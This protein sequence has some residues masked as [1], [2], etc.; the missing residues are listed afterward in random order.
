M[1]KEFF[2]NISIY[3]ILPIVGKF[4]NFLLL[5]VYVKIFTPEEYGVVDLFEVLVLFLFVFASLQIPTAFGR[6]FYENN[7]Q[8]YKK[9]IFCTSFVLTIIVSLITIVVAYLLKGPILRL[10]IESDKYG[11]LFDLSMLWLFVLNINTFLS[12][13]PRY[14]NR[15]K[16]YVIVGIISVAIKLLAS[17][18]FV[19]YL[20]IGL[21]GVIYGYICGNTIS[22]LLYAYISRGYFSLNFS[23]AFAKK[24]LKYVLP[25]LLGAVVIELWKP[26]LRVCINTFFSLSVLGLYAFAAR[27]NSITTIVYGALGTAWMPMLFEKKDKLLENDNIKRISGL[28]ILCAF[29][30][31]TFIMLFARELTLFIGT[32]EY[33]DSVVIIVFLLFAGV[34]KILSQLRGFGPYINDKT[35][36]VTISNVVAS[37]VGLAFFLLIGDRIG[38]CIIGLVVLLYEF[39]NY[40]ILVLYTQ[41]KYKMNMHNRWEIPVLLLMVLSGILSVF[42]TNLLYK[43]LAYVVC[44]A[45]ACVI[46][47][48]HYFK[49]KK[50]SELLALRKR[51]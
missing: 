41:K 36:V 43:A 2:K 33:L 8:E 5:P 40:A 45:V 19:V 39:I 16:L 47:Y 13:I 50:L 27:I 49:D 28:V 15:P 37:L 46:A 26:M 32:A 25:M 38:I 44:F 22:A 48:N 11:N 12:F 17:I 23:S 1:I 51:A 10:Y 35:V 20:R 31:G 34:F 29:V 9:E 30:L 6:Y 7:T 24:T 42:S 14:D 18:F 4:L 3:G 21:P